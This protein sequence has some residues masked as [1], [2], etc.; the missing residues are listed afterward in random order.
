MHSEQPVPTLGL[1]TGTFVRRASAGPGS[2]A[3]GLT[4][5]FACVQGH[6]LAQSIVAGPALGS[7]QVRAAGDVDD[8]GRADFV[9]AVGGVFEVRSGATGTPFPHLSRP[10]A[11][12]SFYLGTLGDLDGDGCDDL[13]LLDRNAASC[14]FVSG[15]TGA[16]LFTVAADAVETARDLDGDGLDDP[17]TRA[18]DPIG[19]IVT[20]IWSGRTTTA[21]RTFTYGPFQLGTITWCGDAD[22]D[23]FEDLL[24]TTAIVPTSAF[25]VLAGPDGATVLSW[26]NQHVAAMGD[27]DGDLR[28]ELALGADIVDAVTLLPVW[29]SPGRLATLRDQCDLDGDGH[30]DLITAGIGTP[31]VALSGRTRQ[32]FAGTLPAPVGATIENLGDV[33][34]DGRD[35]LA[36]GGIVYELAGGPP[37]GVERSRGPGGVLASGS[38]PRARGRGDA[39]VGRSFAVD[40]YGGSPGGFAFL[41]LGPSADLPLPGAPGSRILVQ[42]LSSVLVGLDVRGHAR[43]SLAVPLDPQ[44]IGLAVSCQWLA[45]E[46]AANALGGATSNAWDVLVGG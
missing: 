40:L 30:A 38:R 39:A 5:A 2:H 44:L 23:G 20:T 33:D 10:A 7:T 14:T 45:L 1:M 24:E 35:E 36:I 46:P 3:I 25:R 42:P 11:P 9:V 31:R 19:A 26:G 17:M 8:D 18:T 41:A 6:G 16:V 21:L 32:A 15:A 34:G 12:N 28:T 13:Q 37:S 22:G 43:R 27:T 29:P 4:I